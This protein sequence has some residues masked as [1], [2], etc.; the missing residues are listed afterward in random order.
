MPDAF[1]HI[2]VKEIW[3]QVLQRLAQLTDIGDRSPRLKRVRVKLVRPRRRV[4]WDG[5]PKVITP[6]VTVLQRATRQNRFY[7]R[8]IQR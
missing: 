6:Q 4:G 3:H 8:M 5:R 2:L 1:G 7:D